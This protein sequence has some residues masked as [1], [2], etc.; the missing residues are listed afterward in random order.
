MFKESAECYHQDMDSNK[1]RD[2]ADLNYLY[3]L[4]W[5]L[6]SF[7]YA[8]PSC[9]RLARSGTELKS[10][11]F[12]SQSTIFN[13]VEAIQ[14]KNQ[15]QLA[16]LFHTKLKITPDSLSTY[17]T[18]FDN[19]YGPRYDVQI[20]RVWR[21]QSS[22]TKP[23]E[24]LEDELSLGP[25]YGHE[26]QYAI[27]LQISGER[28]IGRSFFTLVPHQGWKIGVWHTQ[29]WTFQQKDPDHWIDEGLKLQKKS[30]WG[31]FIYLDLAA[32]LMDGAGYLFLQRKKDAEA[33]LQHLFNLE[34]ELKKLRPSIDPAIVGIASAFTPDGPGLE[35]SFVPNPKKSITDLKHDC[36]T[37]IR[38]LLQQ[39]QFSWR[40]SGG[41]RCRF[42]E[43]IDQGFRESPLGGFVMSPTEIASKETK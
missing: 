42:V 26:E 25:H 39:K 7:C 37:A 9:L 30:P 6:S 34:N 5:L 36:R 22:D 24:C 40:T 14:T 35:I 31:A 27:W 12:D 19:I 43:A 8:K 1:T 11:K 23:I 4:I 10:Q 17:F 32:K 2:D 16:G 28:E 41:A 18:S 38:N 13:V 21:L 15:K 20:F 3:L 33:T 29:Q